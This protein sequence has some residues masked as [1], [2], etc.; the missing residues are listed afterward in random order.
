VHTLIF[1]IQAHVWAGQA[2]AEFAELI[3]VAKNAIVESRALMAQ[4][5]QMLAGE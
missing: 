4:I 3:A 1:H 2:Q 5:D